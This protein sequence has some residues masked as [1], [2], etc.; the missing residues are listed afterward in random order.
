MAFFK[1]PDALV[2]TVRNGALLVLPPDYS[3]VPMAAVRALVRKGITDLHLLFMPIGG[4]AGDI[5]IGAGCVKILEA[6]ALSLGEAG[7][8]P[9]FSDAAQSGAIAIKDSTCPAIHSALQ[10]SEKGVP[11]MPLRGVIGSDVLANRPDWKV[12]DDPFD[13]DGG[14]ILLLPAIRPDVALFHAPLADT[15]GNVW[16]GK[17]RE[18]VTMAHASAETLITVERIQRPSLLDDAT[19]AAGTLPAMYVSGITE[20]KGG[21]WPLGLPGH[22]TANLNAIREYARQA[23]TQAGFDAWLRRN[24]IDGQDQMAQQQ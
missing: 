16:I 17:R 24:V 20:A 14:P 11:F 10:A 1:D 13:P 19:T 6:A 12:I 23:K 3:L 9:R 2:A 7:P 22:Y 4:L 8:A 5:L 21:C 15:D 18:L